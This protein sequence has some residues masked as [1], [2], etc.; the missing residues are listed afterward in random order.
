MYEIFFLKNIYNGFIIRPSL[1]EAAGI[2]VP[3]R[4]NRHFNTFYISFPRNE[5]PSVH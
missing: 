1:L 4:N 2:R 3:V 5:C